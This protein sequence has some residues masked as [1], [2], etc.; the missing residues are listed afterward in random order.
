MSCDSLLLDIEILLCICVRLRYT[1]DQLI[2]NV[3]NRQPLTSA[4]QRHAGD[5]WF[6]MT[7][8]KSSSAKPG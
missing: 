8:V 4:L 3:Y 6:E 5:G 2:K 1:I 7:H